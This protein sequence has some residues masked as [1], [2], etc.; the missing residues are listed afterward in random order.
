MQGDEGG[1]VNVLEPHPNLPILATSG[2]DNNI[3]IWGP[4]GD[5]ELDQKKLKTVSDKS[6]SCFL[7]VTL[8][9]YGDESENSTNQDTDQWCNHGG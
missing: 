5:G 2:L 7:Y 1:V 8:Y 3:K 9:Q 6:C 4:T